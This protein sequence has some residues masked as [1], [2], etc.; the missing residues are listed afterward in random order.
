MRPLHCPVRGEWVPQ[1]LRCEECGQ[2]PRANIRVRTP[3]RNAAVVRYR[4]PDGHC[5]EQHVK[6]DLSR[7]RCRVHREVEG[8]RVLPAEVGED[9]VY[10]KGYEVKAPEGVVIDR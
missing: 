7:G 4:C 9:I 8:L 10:R 3:R 5:S 6:P 2:E 1:R